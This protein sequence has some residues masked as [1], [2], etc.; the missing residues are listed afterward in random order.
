MPK[1]KADQRNQRFDPLLVQIFGRIKIGDKTQGETAKKANISE[2]TLSRRK[3]KP[4]D[5]TLG[6]L[7]RLGVLHTNK[8]LH[9]WRFG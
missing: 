6:E 2:A 3:K 5:F 4:E 1:T 9:E 8:E 7:E